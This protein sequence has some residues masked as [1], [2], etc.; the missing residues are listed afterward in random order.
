[1]ELEKINAPVILS[2][3]IKFVMKRIAAFKFQGQ[4]Q[5]SVVVVQIALH[6]LTK[7]VRKV[8]AWM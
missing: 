5:I 2:V 6:Q 3:D 4:V 8:P 1:L 7:H